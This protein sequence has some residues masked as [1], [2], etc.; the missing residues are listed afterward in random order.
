MASPNTSCHFITNAARLDY[1]PTVVLEHAPPGAP[2]FHTLY[3]H[4]SGD[5][6]REL[7]EDSDRGPRGA[8]RERH[9]GWQ[10]PTAYVHDRRETSVRAANQWKGSGGTGRFPPLGPTA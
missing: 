3:G 9:T 5:S 8:Q 10:G 7:S 4:L 2:V 1:G 6:L